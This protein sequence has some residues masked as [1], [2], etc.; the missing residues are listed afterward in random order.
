[1]RVVIG[2][3]D[4]TTHCLE[5]PEGTID[6]IMSRIYE[7]IIQHSRE[8]LWTYMATQRADLKKELVVDLQEYRLIIPLSDQ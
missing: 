6:P 4:E 2:S 1:M 3:I 5:S 7:Q 8:S